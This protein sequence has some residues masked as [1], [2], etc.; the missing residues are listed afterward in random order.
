[1]SGRDDQYPGFEQIRPSVIAMIIY[2]SVYQFGVKKSISRQ[3]M[4][5]QIKV[6]LCYQMLVVKS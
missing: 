5:L 2:Q 4:R 6:F 1:M 3:A